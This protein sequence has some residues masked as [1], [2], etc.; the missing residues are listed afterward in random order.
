VL[1]AEQVQAILPHRPPFIFLDTVEEVNFGESAVAIIDDVA[2]YDYILRGHF[3]GYPVFPGVLLV[4]ALAQLGAV[5]AL[6]VE[7]NRGKLAL[8]TGLDN[9]RFR[10]PAL[11]GKAI[12]LEVKLT[13]FRGNFGKGR[14]RAT[15]GDDLLAEGDILFGIITR[16]AEWAASGGG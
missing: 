9:W 1:D 13:S 11:P 14:G 5:A 6:G 8:L 3:P 10:K 2:R 12:R 16:P 15:A 4:E 7:A